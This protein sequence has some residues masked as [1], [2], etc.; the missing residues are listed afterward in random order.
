MA[1]ELAVFGDNGR[2]LTPPRGWNSFDSYSWSVSEEDFLE[3]AELVSKYLRN[4]GYEVEPGVSSFTSGTD[5]LDAYGRPLPDPDR[6]PSSRNGQGFR[7]VADRVHQLG[8]KL[9]ISVIRGI[10]KAAV[11]LN[12]PI[13]GSQVWLLSSSVIVLRSI[14]T[15]QSE[16][17]QMESPRH[18]G[19]G[20]GLLVHAR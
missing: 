15:G 6:W 10:H 17:I 5:T 20:A 18:R 13:Y 3:N 9:G 8:L 1:V 2:A 16:S 12:T 19:R 7:E 4:F 14:Q 11:E